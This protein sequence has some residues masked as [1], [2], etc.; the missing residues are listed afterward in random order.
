M[1]YPQS[2]YKQFYKMQD[3]EELQFDPRSP[4]PPLD[5]LVHEAPGGAIQEGANPNEVLY[6]KNIRSRTSLPEYP[7][8]MPNVS[9]TAVFGLIIDSSGQVQDI[10]VEESS[11]NILLDQ[12]TMEALH[13][14]VFDV[15]RNETGL[16]SSIMYKIKISY[17]PTT[18]IRL[19]MP[20]Q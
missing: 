2:L 8:N 11:G 12:S 17:S 9:G 15:A 13:G 19:Q 5:V 20:L 3:V 16:R 1:A 6:P 4:V 14:W 18:G 7:R 10:F